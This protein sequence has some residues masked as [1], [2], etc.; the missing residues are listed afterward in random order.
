MEPYCSYY[1]NAGLLLPVTE[2]LTKK[3]MVLPTGTAVSE[4][5]IDCICQIIRFSIA[6]SSEIVE[7][8]ESMAESRSE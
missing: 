1:P 7:A 8:F 6:H 5:E 2:S 4:A 3:V